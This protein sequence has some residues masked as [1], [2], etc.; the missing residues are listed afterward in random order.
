MYNNTFKQ[1]FM[2][3]IESEHMQSLFS[4]LF[5]RS[6]P[7]E[8]EL[9]QDLYDFQ[10]REL[11]SFYYGLETPSRHTLQVFHSLII[12]YVDYAI[13][14]GVRASN[15]NIFRN[16]KGSSLEKY[17]A[18]Y[19]EQYLT[20]QEFNRFMDYVVN[21]VDVAIY[22]CLF[23]GIGGNGYSEF[24]NI[25]IEDIE[26]KNGLSYLS[27]TDIDTQG[28]KTHRQIQ[29]TDT[30]RKDLERANRQ[31]FYVADNGESDLHSAIDIVESPYVFR[32]LKRGAYKK[33]GGQTNMQAIY[34]KKNLLTDLTDGQIK[35]IN[36]LVISGMVHELYLVH[37][38]KGHISDEDF[39]QTG[40]KYQKNIKSEYYATR[41]NHIKNLVRNGL[42]ARYNIKV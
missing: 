32:P 30:L 13:T 16:I 28:N 29:I 11:E 17:V 12:S 42:W 38:E 7:Y 26:E 24:Q 23:E 35:N 5:Y 18:S 36:T 15:I 21:D 37:T 34:R 19:K 9:E 39:L 33:S 6:H 14:Q 31:E 41:V 4:A 22:R 10:T 3:T 8:T 27:L 2:N 20:L 25:K 1:E 40:G